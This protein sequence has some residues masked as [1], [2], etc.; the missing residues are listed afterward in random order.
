MVRLKNWAGI[1]WMKFNMEF[2][3]LRR[4]NS[5]CHFI[6]GAAQLENRFAGEDLRVLIDSVEFECAFTEK[7]A[8]SIHNCIRRSVASRLKEVILPLYLALVRPHL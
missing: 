8:N 4:K 2:F 7:Q 5:G 1:N 3:H 6:L